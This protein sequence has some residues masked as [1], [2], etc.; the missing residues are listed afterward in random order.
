M[1]PFASESCRFLFVSYIGVLKTS[2]QFLSFQ[3]LLGEC[4][5]WNHCFYQK[6]WVYINITSFLCEHFESVFHF[7]CCLQKGYFP[8][9]LSTVIFFCN[10]FKLQRNSLEKIGWV[11]GLEV[12]RSYLT[13][14]FPK[15]RVYHPAKMVSL[16]AECYDTYLICSEFTALFPS[17]HGDFLVFLDPLRNFLWMGDVRLFTQGHFVRKKT[18]YQVTIPPTTWKTPQCLGLQCKIQGPWLV[19]DGTNY[20]LTNRGKCMWKHRGMNSKD[21]FV[22]GVKVHHGG[23]G[24]WLV[25]KKWLVW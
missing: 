4:P 21:T 5:F 3:G 9:P 22:S 16:K 13:L 8:A 17:L 20:P 1:N 19:V 15:A 25:T 12:P 24:W 2:H 11:G 14:T 23:G 18:K 6:T 10:L 7:R